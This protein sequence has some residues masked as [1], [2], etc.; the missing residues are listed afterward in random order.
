MK[1]SET[2]L[3]GAY[4]I[5]LEPVRDERGCFA[6]M[7][8]AEEFRKIGFHK[9]IVQINH[10]LTHMTGTVRG[11]HYQRPPVAETKIIRC[12]RG[13]VF[14]LLVDIREGSPTFLQSHGIEL[15]PENLRM[16]FIPEGFAHGF[17]SLT[18]DAELLY[19]HSA[20][21]DLHSEGG[22]RHDDPALGLRWPLPVRALSP[23]D[24]SHPLID[25]AFKGVCP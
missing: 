8:C 21:H 18:D 13:K 9:P 11:M 12:I 4:M 16:V 3:A 1:F 23:R 22:L 7:F 10:S 25:R 15:S 24:R 19:H 2:P 14:D 6:R 17:Q 20:L 5:E